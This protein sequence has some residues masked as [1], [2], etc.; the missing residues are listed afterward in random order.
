MKKKLDDI[1]TVVK[2]AIALLT[3]KIPEEVH[4]AA[5]QLFDAES[6][7]VR[8][9]EAR[10]EVMVTAGKVELK[11]ELLPVLLEIDSRL[12]QEQ[13]EA[14]AK[15]LL[16]PSEQKHFAR[17]NS[18]TVRSDGTVIIDDKQAVEVDAYRDDHTHTVQITIEAAAGPKQVLVLRSDLETGQ[19]ADLVAVFDCIDGK[20]VD[21]ITRSTA[22]TLAK[23]DPQP[24]GPITDE[25][26]NA[27]AS[28]V[29]ISDVISELCETTVSVFATLPGDDVSC[30]HFSVNSETDESADSNWI[31][32]RPSALTPHKFDCVDLSEHEFFV[33]W[34]QSVFKLLDPSVAS[35]D[36]LTGW[37]V[38]AESVPRQIQ[39]EMHE[40]RLG[41]SG[42][43]SGDALS[44]SDKREAGTPPIGSGSVS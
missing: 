6:S 20:Q 11:E 10:R 35:A 34:S 25:A 17:G 13:I 18:A 19:P 23:W 40:T 4:E 2:E 38:D 28:D 16:L 9:K 14:I 27:M 1:R 22:R 37:L 3:V 31:R 7:G 26:L 39:R 36:E 43:V 29:E 44:I 15:K 32:F 30:I 21:E 12:E 5:Q 8:V 41:A 42:D 24:T 33:V